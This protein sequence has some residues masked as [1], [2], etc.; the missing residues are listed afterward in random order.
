MFYIKIEDKKIKSIRKDISVRRKSTRKI[1][2]SL[3]EI[4]HTN[5]KLIITIYIY[6]RQYSYIE[7]KLN[8][9]MKTYIKKFL[10]FKKY[11]SRNDL[12]HSMYKVLYENKVLFG[13]YFTV[14]T[15]ELLRNNINYLKQKQIMLFNKLKF[16]T[17]ISGIKHIF[18]KIYR[19]NIE[20]NLVSLSNY[21]LNSNILSQII[22]TKVRKKKNKALNVLK[23]SIRNIKTPILND[24]TVKRELVKIKEMQNL[25]VRKYKDYL[26]SFITIKGIK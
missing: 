23:T 14:F 16:N 12:I 3:P 20:F 2:T 8:L 24:T 25:V 22:T 9:K 17:Y 4:K 6:N 5:D 13:Y 1:W 15:K 10:I 18:S 7:D 21:Y 11:N 19:K 26:D